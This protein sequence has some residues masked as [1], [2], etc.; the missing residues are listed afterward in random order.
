[1]GFAKD[2]LRH[3]SDLE[4]MARTVGPQAGAMATNA[5]LGKAK[6]QLLAQAVKQTPPE[7]KKKHLTKR[8]KIAKSSAKHGKRGALVALTKTLPAISLG[9]VK[10]QL[11]FSAHTTGAKKV[12]GIQSTQLGGVTVGGKFF[13]ESWITHT[14]KGKTLQVFKRDTKKTW[15]KGESGWKYWPGKAPRSAFEDYHVITYQIF[16][17]MDKNIAKV[18]M[19][20]TKQH[21]QHEFNRAYYRV[22][23]KRLTR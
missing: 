2:M 4:F 21:Y 18:T 15:R 16:D 23:N 10:D 12:R 9:V 6:T 11:R 7:L 5:V 20:A 3:E 19:K 22:I 13:R 1:M 14:R 8:L 17:V